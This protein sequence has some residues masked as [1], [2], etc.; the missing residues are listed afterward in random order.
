V[1]VR[2]QLPQAGCG[3]REQLDQAI[4]V[5]THPGP[6]ALHPFVFSRGHRWNPVE[7]ESPTGCAAAQRPRWRTVQ[8]LQIPPQLLR[9]HVPGVPGP[10]G[11]KS[12]VLC[13]RSRSAPLGLLRRLGPAPRCAADLPR[14]PALQ[15][16][17]AR[18]DRPV[19]TTTT[20]GADPSSPATTVESPP[21]HRACD[22]GP[23][24]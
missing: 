17:A 4:T 11:G 21:G 6:R 24:S 7:P 16:P 19:R 8:M 10:C 22:I 2:P 3:P 13:T 12:V 23:A 14:P 20:R 15:L 1:D 5:R 18:S 9:V